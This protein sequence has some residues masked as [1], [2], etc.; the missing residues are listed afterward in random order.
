[1]VGDYY[2]I[3][4]NLEDIYYESRS[5]ADFRRFVMEYVKNMLSS[6]RESD[7]LTL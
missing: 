5:K 4:D 6:Y 2:E 7:T 1:M 3:G